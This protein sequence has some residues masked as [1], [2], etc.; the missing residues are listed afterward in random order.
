MV[1]FA[2]SSC[3]IFQFYRRLNV[4]LSVE[5]CSCFCA[6]FFSAKWNQW[7]IVNYFRIQ[8]HANYGTG[9]KLFQLCTMQMLRFMEA[10][11]S[12][13]RNFLLIWCCISEGK[14]MKQ[15]LRALVK[16]RQYSLTFGFSLPSYTQYHCR[17]QIKIHRENRLS[18]LVLLVLMLPFFKQFMFIPWVK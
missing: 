5:I 7:F 9:V 6:C 16:A 17:L 4:C 11:D 2:S 13:E 12:C 18:M 8:N 14:I 1:A 3:Q 15:F 10:V